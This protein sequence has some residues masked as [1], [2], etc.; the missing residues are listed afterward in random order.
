MV[1]HVFSPVVT[2]AERCKCHAEIRLRHE[3]L[4]LRKLELTVQ[5]EH[6]THAGRAGEATKKWPK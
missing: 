6:L 2:S 3:L 1:T 5:D 4:A